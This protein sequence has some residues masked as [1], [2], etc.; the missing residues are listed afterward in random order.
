MLEGVLPDCP[1]VPKNG[2]P[3]S[4]SRYGGYLE[5]KDS[6][7]Y[8]DDH[9]LYHHNQEMSAGNPIVDQQVC[10]AV[11]VVTSFIRARACTL[12]KSNSTT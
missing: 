8:P 4:V 10:G 11:C 3:H 9:T 5:I 6:S 2:Y 12:G 7:T 1:S